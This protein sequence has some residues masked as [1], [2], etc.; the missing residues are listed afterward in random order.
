MQDRCSLLGAE[1]RAGSD[2]QSVRAAVVRGDK[3]LE[4]PSLEK[5]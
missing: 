2:L 3:M 4:K 1:D 5:V